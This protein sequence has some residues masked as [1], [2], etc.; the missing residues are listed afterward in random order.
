MVMGNTDNDKL[1]INPDGGYKHFVL[2]NGDFIILKGSVPGTYRRL[3]KL[4]SQIRNAPAKVNKPN[5][6]EVV[7]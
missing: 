1:K 7:I 2:V 4:R 3:I 5:I 6:L